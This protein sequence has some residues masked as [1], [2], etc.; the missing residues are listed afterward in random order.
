MKERKMQKKLVLL[1]L[2]A[3]LLAGGVFAQVNLSA[4]FGGTFTADFM[5]LAWTKDGKDYLDLYSDYVKKDSY[6]QNLVG[7]G[8]Y[9]YFDATYAMLSLGMSFY[10]IKYANADT[11][12]SVSL[13]GKVQR[14]LT[15]FDI[16]LYGKFPI[17]L[18]AATLFPM[19]G[20][21]AKIAVAQDTIND[22]KKYAY[23]SEEMKYSNKDKPL[24]EYWSTVWFKF[25]VGGDIPLGEKLYLRPMFLYGFGTVPKVQKDQLDEMNKVTKMADA[26]VH[27][28]DIKVA[29]G[30]KF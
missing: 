4:G 6:D 22:G 24:A 7:G 20:V 1:L 26:I 2:M 21:D 16:G 15:T 23:D 27:G 8:F 25:G 10:D 19:L 18:G 12:K 11:Q 5:N 3:T 9:A 17:S 14:S 30:F 29:V 28:L 13:D